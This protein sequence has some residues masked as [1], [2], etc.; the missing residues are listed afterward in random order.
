MYVSTR[1]NINTKSYV[2][3]YCPQTYRYVVADFRVKLNTH[4]THK[5]ADSYRSAGFGSVWDESW[6]YFNLETNLVPNTHLILEHSVR[7]CWRLITSVY[8][9]KSA[10]GVLRESYNLF[11]IMWMGLLRAITW[12]S[13]VSGL[14]TLAWRGIPTPEAP[15]TL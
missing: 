11:C 13:H 6:H 10:A 12:P 7:S 2:L 14:H 8:A 5:H 4:E 3:N 1:R 15:R 9:R